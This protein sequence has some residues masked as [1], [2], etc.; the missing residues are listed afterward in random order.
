M[1]VQLRVVGSS[2]AWPNPGDAQS[3]YL[4]EGSGRLLLDCGPGVLAKLREEDG[5]WPRVD[6]IVISH[7]HLDHWGDLVPW[8][9]GVMAGPG[10]QAPRPELWL[11]PGGA[12]RLADFG[13]RLGWNEMFAS[14]FQ[15]REYR[16][17]EQFE[18]AGFTVFP[19]ELPHYTL[20]TFGFRVT[21]GER[22]LAYSGDSGPSPRLAEL[23]ADADLFVCEATL[24]RGE[25]DGPVRGHLAPEEACD[26]FRSSAARRLL[27]THRPIELPLADGLERAYDGLSIVL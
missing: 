16:D 15:L 27:I 23:A 24:E 14:P 4:V 2:P 6:A 26:A 19:L 3:G 12:A 25:L 22:V 1:N 13:T 9:W 17:G 18:A 8:T 21:D 10:Q 5:G 7:W 11:P 20:H